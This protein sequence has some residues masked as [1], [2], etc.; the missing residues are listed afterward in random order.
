MEVQVGRFISPPDIEAQLAPNNYLY[1]HSLLFTFDAFTQTGVLSSIKLSD[2][3]SIMLGLHCGNDTWCSDGSAHKPTYE[4]LGRWISK[5]NKDSVFFGVDAFNGAPVKTYT[6][7][8]TLY[9]H[10]NLQQFNATWTHVFNPRFH[11]LT[12]MYYIF[13]KDA[14]AGGSINNGPVQFGSGGGPGAF[15]P[16]LST[17]TAVVNYLE[18]KFSPND[19]ASLR[20]EYVNDPRGQRS[21]F[22]T[23]YSSVTLGVTHKFSKTLLARPEIRL[24]KAFAGG[25]TPYDNGTK[26]Y[27]TSIGLDFIQSFGNP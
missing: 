26:K 11:T 9:G 6:I 1:S 24:E 23:A 5:S 14:Y 8:S 15:L 2:N 3:W 16:G 7:G 18:D 4:A 22:A 10:D 17:S 21:G 20:T 13:S 25:V 12:E 27:Q 19:F